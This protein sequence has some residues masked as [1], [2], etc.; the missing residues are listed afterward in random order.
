MIYFILMP[1]NLIMSLLC[2]ITN[3]IVVFFASETGELPGVLKYW[4]TWDDAID[5]RFF[6]LERVPKV[7]RYDFDSKYIEGRE[8]TPELLA[9]GRDKG[10]VFLRQ[11][12]SFSIKERVQRYFCRVLWLARN[13]GYGFAFYLFGRIVNGLDVER[14]KEIREGRNE[15]L[16]AW[17]KT[18]SIYIRPWIFCADWK[19][20][21]RLRWNVFLGW[22]INYTGQHPEM[23]MIANRIAFSI[24]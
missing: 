2:Y 13:D 20:C 22:K 1:L 4:Q 24:D 12:A 15:L 19:I 18:K 8:T 17:D 10:C 16:F 3:P 9:V 21:G 5:V 7:F 23:A 11:G 6:V 14:V